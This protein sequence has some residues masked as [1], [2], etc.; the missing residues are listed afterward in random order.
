[1]PVDTPL[2]DEESCLSLLVQFLV[3]H[4]SGPFALAYHPPLLDKGSIIKMVHPVVLTV[5]DGVTAEAEITA[6]R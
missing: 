2:L 4:I 6:Y 5:T 3:P 1:M